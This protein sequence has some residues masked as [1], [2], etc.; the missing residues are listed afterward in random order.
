MP[1]A[2][3]GG[4]LG[5]GA[6]GEGRRVGE[7]CGLLLEGKRPARPV[8]TLLL[9]TGLRIESGTVTAART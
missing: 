8:V 6:G 9:F 4:L 7:P 3:R 1:V 5:V 2:Q